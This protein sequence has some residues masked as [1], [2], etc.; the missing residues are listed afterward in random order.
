MGNFFVKQQINEKNHLN[1]G[2][3]CMVSLH[4]TK[5]IG[6]G[7]GGFIV[8]D[9]KYLESIE[10]SICFGFT[11]KDRLHFDKNASNYKMSEI[12]A[13]YID[14]FLMKQ[15]NNI[16]EHHTKM[17]SYFLFKMKEYNLENKIK[18]FKTYGSYETSLFANIPILFNKDTDIDVFIEN[19]IEAKK[20]Y[21]PL[22]NNC[23]VSVDLFN[24]IICIPLNTDT[25]E[26]DI[27]IYINI[28]LTI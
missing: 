2:I 4:H 11:S 8:I 18:L 5:P 1:Y 21:Y 15:F 20:Y 13:I 7:E 26:S 16:Y 24:K 19:N 27:D 22:D 10:K 6:F 12:N 28:L 14:N 25:N 9:N 23:K 17:L 3:G